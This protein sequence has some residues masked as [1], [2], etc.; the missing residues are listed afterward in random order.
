MP[1]RNDMT[2]WDEIACQ[3]G[4]RSH[5]RITVP[6]HLANNDSY[7]DYPRV[8]KR[9][10][11]DFEMEVWAWRSYQQ[12]GPYCP[13]HDVV[14]EVIDT[15]GVWEQC[16]TAVM[17]M[18]FERVGP[19]AFFVDF[20]CQVGWYSV[21]AGRMGLNVMAIDADIE[22]VDLTAANLNRTTMNTD[23]TYIV[24]VERCTADSP[25]LPSMRD[26]DGRRNPVVVKIDVEG[27]EQHAIAMLAPH[28][29][30]V[31]FALIEISPVFNDSY[32]ALVQRMLDWGF[33]PYEIPPRGDPPIKLDQLADLIPFHMDEAAIA[34]I[35]NLHQAN[36]LF[37][38]GGV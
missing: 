11:D 7:H 31:D 27:A 13:G 12:D 35:P 30:D 3:R 34:N 18:V 38:R 25:P 29:D 4:H 9:F 6:V 1:H 21:L 19:G 8:P 20:G 17:M 10:V 32:P 37:V 23:M 14:S 2:Y 15:L 24:G 36:W 16:E 5:F 33:E 22:C 28:I 26:E